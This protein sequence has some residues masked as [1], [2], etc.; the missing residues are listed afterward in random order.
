[1]SIRCSRGH[2]NPDGSL[3]CDECGER[4]APV[5]VSMPRTGAALLAHPRLVLAADGT[6]FDLTGKREI[7]LGRE[8]PVSNIFPDVDLTD[9]GGEEGGVSRTH[10][11]ISLR[12]GRYLIE[13]LNSTNCTYLNRQKLTPRTPTLLN[14]GDEIRL[15]RVML[16]FHLT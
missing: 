8:D 14:D 11:R 2:D 1:M 12:D 15:G 13:D 10:A 7:L 9:H 6:S 4:L 16:T 3:Y 5:G